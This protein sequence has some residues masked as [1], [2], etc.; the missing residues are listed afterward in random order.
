VLWM[1]DPRNRIHPSVRSENPLHT[2]PANVGRPAWEQ[3][4]RL[5]PCAANH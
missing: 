1:N 4:R 2:N 3:R 5:R